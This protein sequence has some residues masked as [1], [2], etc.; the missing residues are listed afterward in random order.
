MG[1][2]TNVLLGIALAGLIALGWCNNKG[3]KII[4]EKEIKIDSLETKIKDV[5]TIGHKKD[6]TLYK[7]SK[8]LMDTTAFYSDSL[9]KTLF[10]YNNFKSETK[11]FRNN[12][13]GLLNKLNKIEKEKRE[14]LTQL[15]NYDSQKQ[16]EIEKKDGEYSILGNKYNEL[17][18]LYE[19]KSAEKV[20][21]KEINAYSRETNKRSFNIK[22]QN[23]FRNWKS[24]A[25]KLFSVGEESIIFKDN[26]PESM[27]AF[28]IYP[29]TDPKRIEPLKKISGGD[30]SS[31]FAYPKKFLDEENCIIEVYAIDKHKNESGRR[32]IYKSGG[33][34]SR[35]EIVD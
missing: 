24:L 29:E 26:A 23:I 33:V 15:K 7:L 10:L 30:K 34:I 13:F 35:K 1:K 5:L 28:A 22:N 18:N 3:K 19:K 32:T 9:K 31:N 2:K 6:L 8:S 12:Y 25:P 20:I 27:E 4:D 21:E 17:L 16:K 11:S 14:L